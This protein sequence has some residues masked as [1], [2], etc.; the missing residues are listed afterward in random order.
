M[1]QS[2]ILESWTARAFRP[3]WP[4]CRRQLYLFGHPGRAWLAPFGNPGSVAV[5]S[6]SPSAILAAHCSLGCSPSGLL[7]RDD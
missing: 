5:G 6:S 1:G 7:A 4:R 2:A 3:C